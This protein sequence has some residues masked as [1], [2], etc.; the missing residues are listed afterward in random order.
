MEHRG[1]RYE[2]KVAPGGRQWV[3]IVHTS[4]NPK[5]GLVEGGPRQVAILAAEKA[6]NRWWQQRH[7]LDAARTIRANGGPRRPLPNR[8]I[9]PSR[10]L[11]PPTLRER[12]HHGPRASA[13]SRASRASLRAFH[14]R[15]CQRR[16]LEAAPRT[17]TVPSARR[18]LRTTERAARKT[19]PRV[20]LTSTSCSRLKR[21]SHSCP[22]PV[23]E[24]MALNLNASCF[25]PASE[26]AGHL[27][28]S[29]RATRCPTG[30][31]PAAGDR[32]LPQQDRQGE[33]LQAHV[34]LVVP[35]VGTP[36]NA[37]LF[38]CLNGASRIS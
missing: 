14:R 13:Y 30:K 8:T 33:V 11:H 22:S 34:T 4:P 10:L 23:R 32:I 38:S 7:G 3:W 17:A 26:R 29:D 15:L 24:L 31:K 20:V 9:L 1:V 27:S 18:R 16:G 2:I 36:E 5:R 6:I 25:S 12:R 35:N 37:K 21:G 19:R 28:E